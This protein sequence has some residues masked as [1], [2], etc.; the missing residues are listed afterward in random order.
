MIVLKMHLCHSIRNVNN[1][2]VLNVSKTANKLAFWALQNTIRIDNQ[3]I[4]KHEYLL[5]TMI[6]FIPVCQSV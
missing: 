5:S 2:F 6:F 1:C 3:I 4:A